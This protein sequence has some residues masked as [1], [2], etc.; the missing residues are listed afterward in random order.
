MSVKHAEKEPIK[1]ASKPNKK[2]KKEGL[3]GAIDSV[4][5]VRKPYSGCQANSL[6]QPVNPLMGLG[7]A[8][9]TPDQ[10]HAVY[11]DQE[12]AQRVAE[13]LYKEFEIQEQQLEEKKMK[14]VEA[15]KKKI[16]EMEKL[17]KEN[18]DMIKENPSS[19]TEYKQKVAEL[20]TKIDELVNTLE[21]V[22]K[23]KKHLD[24]KEKKEDKKKVEEA[25]RKALTSK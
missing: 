4:Y 7:G 25:L 20:A 1:M 11:P 6:V 2:M 13:T 10:V 18:V 16:D 24:K 14:V 23:S 5:A 12:M 15:I 17:R 21:R 8:E 3:E 19:V 9:Y 22:E